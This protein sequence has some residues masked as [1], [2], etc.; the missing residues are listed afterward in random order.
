MRRVTGIGGVFFSAK[1]QK[2]LVAWFVAH[3]GSLT[4]LSEVR[5]TPLSW[6]LIR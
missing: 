3:R 4:A 1:D 6:R 2:A 5:I